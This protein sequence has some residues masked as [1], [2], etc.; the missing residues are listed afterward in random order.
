MRKGNPV[1]EVVNKLDAAGFDYTTVIDPANKKMSIVVNP[2][3]KS[4]DT[5]NVGTQWEAEA[6]PIEVDSST[7]VI[8][9][10]TVQF[11]LWFSGIEG[12]NL[13]EWCEGHPEDYFE[14]EVK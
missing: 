9:S 7:Y 11:G 4:T 10:F 13:E 12:I 5:K 2:P 6:E 1:S 3:F 8:K 14:L